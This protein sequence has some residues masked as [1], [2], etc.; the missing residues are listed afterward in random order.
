MVS[1]SNM[2]VFALIIL[3]IC[4]VTIPTQAQSDS[5]EGLPLLRDG[6]SVSIIYTD[7]QNE[8]S[9]PLGCFR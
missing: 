6:T 2:G 5:A 7:P 8:Y 1:R 3:M 4:V 9:E